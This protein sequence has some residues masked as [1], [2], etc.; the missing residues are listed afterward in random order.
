MIFYYSI[1]VTWIGLQ[2]KYVPNISV[3][4]IL[5]YFKIMINLVKVT[6]KGFMREKCLQKVTLHCAFTYNSK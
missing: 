2:E 6:T 5:V 4:A 3:Y 1:K